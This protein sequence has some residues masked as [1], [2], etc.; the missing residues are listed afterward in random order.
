M[1][2]LPHSFS[3]SGNGSR[4]PMSVS[5]ENTVVVTLADAAK[6]T[7]VD[8]E[9]LVAR[10]SPFGHSGDFR[11]DQGDASDLGARFEE[12]EALYSTVP[13]GLALIGCDGRFVRINQ[14]LA[15]M[16]GLPAESHLGRTPREIVPHLADQAD[17][18]LRRVVRTGQP[19][20]DTPFQGETPARPGVLR[21]WNE[22]WHP[23]KDRTGRV[24]AVNVIV[25]EITDRR[26][27][28][29]ALAESVRIKDALYR[30]TDRLQR[31]RT[32]EDAYAASL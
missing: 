19:V 13:C 6:Q 20:L 24:I 9:A 4:N 7:D 29:A 17:E 25:E 28:E 26:Q 18:V 30:L 31:A 5:A 12:L 14:R 8:S 2:S 1:D 10:R 3:N 16:N 27:I 32:L 11:L 22:S 15:E 21:S 23:V